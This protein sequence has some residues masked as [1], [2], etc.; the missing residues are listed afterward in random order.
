M[1]IG[2]VSTPCVWGAAR[3]PAPSEST[4]A[5]ASLLKRSRS[6]K[7]N[8]ASLMGRKVASSPAWKEGGNVMRTGHPGGEGE[9]KRRLT[10]NDRP[11]GERKTSHGDKTADDEQEENCIW[12]TCQKGGKGEGKMEEML[13]TE[14]EDNVEF[15]LAGQL[16][17]DGGGGGR[18]PGELLGDDWDGHRG[19]GDDDDQQ[20]EAGPEKRFGE[21]LKEGHDMIVVEIQ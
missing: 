10:V 1:G 12:R 3:A 15:F 20:I 9:R 18:G 19:E 5:S 2:D 17:R 11:W 6:R 7:A 14:C 13:F 4:T 21:S 8:T 16:R